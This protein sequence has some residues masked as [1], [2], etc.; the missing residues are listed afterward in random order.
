[1]RRTPAA[2]VVAVALTSLVACGHET[3]QVTAP[4]APA[5]TSAR[6][7]TSTTPATV[8]TPSRAP[9]PHRRPTARPTVVAVAAFRWHSTGVSARA[10]GKSWHSGCPVAPSGLRSVSLSYWGFDG[11]AHQGDLVVNARVVTVVVSVFRS[12]YAARFPIRLMRPIASYGGSDD[13]SMAA[14]NTSAYNCRYAVSNGPKHWSMHA[15]GEAVDVDPLENP[16]RLDGKVLPPAG[17]PYL[18]RSNVRPGMVVRGSEPV[19]AFAGLGWGW[20]GNWSSSPD[21][22]HFSSTGQ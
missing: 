21:Y 8:P 13:R 20:G 22:Q 4:A 17:A 1:M 15:Y 9:V 14:D 2:A 18:D 16:Y 12:L 11:A 7:A 19:R 6:S 5:P 3:P 10:L